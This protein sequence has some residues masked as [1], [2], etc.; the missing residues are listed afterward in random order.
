[1]EK[2][3]SP[4]KLI[5]PLYIQSKN[6][7]DF[8]YFDEKLLVPLKNNVSWDYVNNSNDSWIMGIAHICLTF[9]C[10][11]KCFSV[12]TDFEANVIKHNYDTKM[13][14]RKTDLVFSIVHRTTKYFLEI[15]PAD[16]RDITEKIVFQEQGRKLSIG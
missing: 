12:A 15:N 3:L 1:M 8:E 6:Q 4:K 9:S 14:A 10:Y 7:N 11:N 5:K 2:C 16:T 13:N